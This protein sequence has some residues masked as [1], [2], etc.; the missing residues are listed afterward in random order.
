MSI[1][2]MFKSFSSVVKSSS[3]SNLIGTSLNIPSLNFSN[4]KKF[5]YSNRTV[6][7]CPLNETV[8]DF[9]NLFPLSESVNTSDLPIIG[10]VSSLF[11]VQY[12]IEIRSSG[13]TPNNVRQLFDNFN[14]LSNTS[15]VGNSSISFVIVVTL[16]FNTFLVTSSKSNEIFNIFL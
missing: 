6:R 13:E 5:P 1:F 11:T 15:I 3:D 16:K 14:L 4:L 2:S 8:F 10:N 12:S 7:C 9:V